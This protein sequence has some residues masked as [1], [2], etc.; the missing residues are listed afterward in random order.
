MQHHRVYISADIEGVAGVVNREQLSPRGFEYERARAWMTAE[1]VAAC[2]G[3]FAAGA[4]DIVVSDSH[5]NGQNILLD[6]LPAR[7]QLVRSWPRPLGMMEG[8]QRG[9]FDAALLIG[10]HCGISDPRG[11]LSHTLRSDL[12]M[13]VRYNGQSASETLISAAV[14]GH[15]GVPIAMVSGDDGYCEHAAELLGEHVVTVAT[16]SNIGY[17]STQTLTPA[18]SVENIRNGAHTALQQLE[19][20]SPYKVDPPIEIEVDFVNRTNAETLAYLPIFER[21]GANTLAYQARDAD[22]AIRFLSFLIHHG[23]SVF[24]MVPGF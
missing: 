9:R 10:Y 14:G 8:L 12:I 17:A 3:A 16:K 13:D 19:N 7:V 20:L 15:F 24:P 6:K 2:D 18:E 5:G 22:D 23:T 1:V 4:T 21:R 11:G